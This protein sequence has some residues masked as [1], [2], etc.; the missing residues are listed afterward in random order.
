MSP[1]RPAQGLVRPYV[2]TNGRSE[3]SRNTFDLVTLV[4]GVP[5]RPL[6]CLGPEHRRLVLLVRAGALSVAEIAAHLHLPV[7]ICKVLLGDLVDSGHL[8]TRAPVPRAQL[9]TSQLLQE[10]LDGLRARL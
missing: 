6:Q 5:D 1:R 7:S 8:L 4:I 3:P 10:V 9:P 2:V